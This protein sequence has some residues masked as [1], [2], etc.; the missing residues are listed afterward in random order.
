L[1]GDTGAEKEGAE[2]AG[3]T[4]PQHVNVSVNLVAALSKLLVQLQ[5]LAD[6][7]SVGAAGVAKLELSDYQNSPFSHS[8]QLAGEHRIPFSQIKERFEV[9]CVK[10]S[11]TE[12]I[13]VLS[14]FLEECRLVAALYSIGNRTISSWEWKQSVVDAENRFH[15]LPFPDKIEELRTKYNV[16]S[17][18]EEFVLSLN[19]ARRCLIHR[20]GVVSSN[21]T[22]GSE[23]LVVKWHTITLF[24]RDKVTGEEIPVEIGKPAEHESELVM[25]AG[26]SERRFDLKEQIKLTPTELF[27][28][29]HTFYLFAVD[30]LKAL[31]RMAPAAGQV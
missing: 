1:P 17:D 9:W 19:A 16:R 11:F 14:H 20:L 23:Y 29:L 4:P 7:V 21:D 15:R 30:L 28:T 3:D 27:H 13:D 12:A 5:H 10:N 24:L 26:P 25:R 6:F 8:Y 22:K 31:E 18:F 2:L